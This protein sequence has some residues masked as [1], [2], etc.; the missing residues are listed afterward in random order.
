VLVIESKIPKNVEDGS[1]DGRWMVFNEAVPNNIDD[2]VALPLDTRLHTRFQ[3]DK[4]RFSPDG[5][6]LAYQPDES[7]LGP[8]LPRYRELAV[9]IAE[10]VVLRQSAR[11]RHERRPARLG[12]GYRVLNPVACIGRIVCGAANIG[13]SPL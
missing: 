2:L 4:G 7:G 5:K 6:W 11:H 8:R 9:A 3:E 13:C 10:K 12:N 1:A